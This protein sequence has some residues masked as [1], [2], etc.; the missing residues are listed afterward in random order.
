M[1]QLESAKFIDDNKGKSQQEKMEYFTGIETNL[2]I[3]ESFPK[4]EEKLVGALTPHI[5]KPTHERRENYVVQAKQHLDEEAK[6][7]VVKLQERVENITSLESESEFKE[8]G[9]CLAI[10]SVISEREGLFTRPE[11]I[12]TKYRESKQAVNVT[13]EKQQREIAEMPKEKVADI[14]EKLT[15]LSKFETYCEDSQGLHSVVQKA[16]K[17]SLDSI[18]KNHGRDN[19]FVYDL[20]MKLK[21]NVEGHQIVS[22]APMF[23]GVENSLFNEAIARKGISEVLREMEEA[24]SDHLDSDTLLIEYERCM[25]KYRETVTKYLKKNVDFDSLIRE[26]SKWRNKTEITKKLLESLPDLVALIFALWTLLSSEHFFSDDEAKKL[27]EKNLMELKQPHA[28]QVVSIFRI[29]GIG[30]SKFNLPPESMKKKFKKLIGLKSN[31]L[32][33]NN[34]VQILTGEGKSITLATVGSV[35][36]ILGFDVSIACYSEYLSQRDFED[37]EAMFTLLGIIDN[38][39]YDT[40]NSLCERQLNKRGSIRDMVL[41][42]ILKGQRPVKSKDQEL[43]PAVLLIDEVDVFFSKAFYNQVYMPLL[44]LHDEEFVRLLDKIWEEREGID[45]KYTILRASEEFKACKA[46][47]NPKYECLMEEALKDIIGDLMS[48]M[49]DGHDYLIYN[50]EI[51]YRMLDTISTK[52]KYGYKTVFAYYQAFYVSKQIEDPEV[53]K[54]NRYVQFNCAEFSYSEVPSEFQYTFGVT[55]TLRALTPQQF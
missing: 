23:K 36:A 31:P 21:D 5:G 25:K 6:E 2:K 11:V 9:Q 18:Q 3:V 42:K 30:Y 55:G 41:H 44:R 40:F 17:N 14:A 43:R 49:V 34:L 32:I 29:F 37:F 4:I 24:G 15:T 35:F 48:F 38:V 16:I 22:R 46:L 10:A 47:F 1:E 8:L 54:R 51:G 12:K 53:F 7:V 27:D 50:G 52:V 39:V 26:I 33:V 45:K 20:N 19:I 28:A 13:I